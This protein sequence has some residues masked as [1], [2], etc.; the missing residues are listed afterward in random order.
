L[1]RGEREPL[2]GRLVRLV[3]CVGRVGLWMGEYEAGRWGC[4]GQ[5]FRLLRLGCRQCTRNDWVLGCH[6]WIRN[7]RNKK[8][9]ER[10]TRPFLPYIT[11]YKRGLVV[12][13]RRLAPGPA[14]GSS[15]RAW[16]RGRAGWGR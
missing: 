11:R 15:R 8:G 10:P 12:M 16:P 13:R 14:A 9:D 2:V 7:G 1:S 4:D 5:R 6:Q 3:D